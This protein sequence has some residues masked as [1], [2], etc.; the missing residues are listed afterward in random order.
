MSAGSRPLRIA[1]FVHDL[2]DPAV[3]RRVGMLSR[4]GG[5]VRLLGFHRGAAAPE[6]VA[7]VEALSLGRTRDGRMVS[8][9]ASVA[10][11]L[12]RGL[13]APAAAAADVVIARNL[14]MLAVAS[15]AARH[16]TLVYECL[17][18]HRL[19]LSAGTA[20]RVLRAVERRLLGRVRLLLVSSPAFL[21]GY[22][23]PKQGY[24]GPTM[25]L[26]NKALALD[27]TDPGRPPAATAARPDGPPWRIG[28][29]GMIRCAR[30]L[31]MLIQLSEQLEGGLEVLIAGRPAYDQFD[32]FDGQVARAR[33]VRFTGGYAP[34]DLPALYG[35]VHFT[36]AIDYFEEGL[37]S[38]WLLP[39]RLYE[40]GLYG[41]TPIALA[42]V[43]TGRWLAR[44]GAGVLIE[45]PLAELAPLLE[46]LRPADYAA[47]RRASLAIPLD[48]LRATET[49]C[50]ALVAKLEALA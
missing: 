34:A 27:A 25:L 12:A 2:N 16:R 1:Y 50:T 47:L 21:S 24:G 41:S 23:Q 6:R 32:D 26:E 13:G 18:I 10:V 44:R 4:G 17:D 7:G 8:R 48:D 11:A 45:D 29:F 31:R 43:E 35:G 28:W 30:S 3:A 5:Q 38:A 22:L 14:E 33:F 20:G 9:A 40:G 19:L 15:G 36:W 39:N 49:D 46:R 42:S 37:N